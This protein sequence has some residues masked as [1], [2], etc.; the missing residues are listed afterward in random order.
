MS[1]EPEI[2]Y[3]GVGLTG[4]GHGDRALPESEIIDPVGALGD[5]K[6]GFA[7]VS[8]SP[9]CEQVFILPF[10]GPAVECCIESNPLH[11]EEDWSW[12]VEIDSAT[13]WESDR[14]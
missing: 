3:I 5:G 8:L 10:D 11:E 7:V 4:L 13:P 14:G 6:E 2:I 1:G 12:G 9:Y